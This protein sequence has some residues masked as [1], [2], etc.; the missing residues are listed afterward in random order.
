MPSHSGFRFGIGRI[1]SRR[2][3]GPWVASR[4]EVAS[5]RPI[6]G[7]LLQ[8][9]RIEFHLFDSQIWMFTSM[10]PQQVVSCLQQLG[11]R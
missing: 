8:G 7:A 4:G 3:A 6:V 10:N 11:Y 9:T 2:I 5:V 1:G